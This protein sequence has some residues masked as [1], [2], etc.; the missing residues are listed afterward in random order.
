MRWW[1]LPTAV[2]FAG[3]AYADEL[4]R[5]LVKSG[6]WAAIEYA[7]AETASPNV[8]LAVDATAGMALRAD[9]AGTELVVENPHWDLPAVVRWTM[10][11]TV[12]SNTR[13]LLITRNTTNTVSA[14]IDPPVLHMLFDEMAMAAGM[15]VVVGE[16]TPLKVSLAGSPA[17][18]NAFRICAIG[19]QPE[20]RL[21]KGAP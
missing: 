19:A 16:T 8:C 4:A 18:L 20:A 12:G 5:S 9:P 7:P 10:K 3:P 1:L 17:V 15:R 13:T 21:K 11:V 6:D 14:P 2:V